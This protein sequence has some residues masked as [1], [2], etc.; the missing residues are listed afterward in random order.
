[1][2]WLLRAADSIYVVAAIQDS[3][4]SGTDAFVVSLNTGGERRS[5]PDHADFQ[6]AFQRTLDSSIVYRGRNGRWEP[7][8]NDPDWRLGRDRSGA[9]WTVTSTQEPR[10]WSLVLRL[11]PAWLDGIG[12]SRPSIA[13]RVSDDRPRGWYSWPAPPAGVRA[14]V[15][16]DRPELW[17]IVGG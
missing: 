17:V 1:V 7:P 13:F 10:G 14:L 16:E 12:A 6:W 15:V 11:D 9:G 5:R 8:R 2:V 3:T 4:P